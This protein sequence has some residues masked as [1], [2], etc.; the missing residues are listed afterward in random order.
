MAKRLTD[1]AISN[2]KPEAKRREIPDPGQRGLYIVVQP[3]GVKSF[4]VR[5]RFNGK[6]T[7]LTLK[8]GI[9]L[10]AARKEAAAALYEVEKGHDP[11]ATKKAAKAEQRTSAATTFRS[12]AEQYMTVVA[13]MRREGDQVTFNGEIRTAHRRLRDLERAIFPKLG[14]RP[15][16]EI[17]RSEINSLLD[18][19]DTKS[20]PVAADRALALIRTIMNWHAARADSFVPPIVRKMARTSTKKRAR[21]RTLTDDEIRAI[22]NSKE[23]GAFPALLKFLL[24]TGARRAEAANMRWEEIDGESWTLPA[25]RNKANLDLVRPLSTAA[26]AVIES[27]KR[28]CPFIFSKGR[29]AISTFSRDKMAFDEAIGISA[30]RLKDMPAYRLH[31]LRRTARTLLSRAGVVAD[32]G[33]H[34]LGHVPPG[35]R[36]TYDRYEYFDEKKHA[37]DALA[38]LIERIASPPRDNVRALRKNKPA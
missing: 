17:K 13:K 8:S 31:D 21:R 28:D 32:I 5:Y 25:R 33:E 34:C 35:I 29:K 18:D 3:S 23:S 12:I 15:I 1:I 38:S 4:A 6:P 14:H 24:L 9:T 10:A 37:Y 26:L 36:D 30:H 20:G 11:S 22:W 27:Q 16:A 19:I 7:K 2:L